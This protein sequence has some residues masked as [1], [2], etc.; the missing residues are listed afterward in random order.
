MLIIVIYRA[1]FNPH[2][3]VMST[4]NLLKWSLQVSNGMEF[5]YHTKVIHGDLAARNV[6]LSHNLTA[7][8]GDFGLSRQLFE[9]ANYIK[10]QQVE[11]THMY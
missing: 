11:D 1:S 8:I 2:T 10:K 5:L 3:Q 4:V 7:K 9:Y 6:L